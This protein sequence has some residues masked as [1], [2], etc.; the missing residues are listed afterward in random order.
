MALRKFIDVNT[1]SINSSKKDITSLFEKQLKIET[2][3]CNRIS[4][5]NETITQNQRS[6]YDITRS[7]D[8]NSS[9]RNIDVTNVVND[10]VIV[11]KP[12][13]EQGVPGQ[14]GEQG[15]PGPIGEQG[16]DGPVGEQGIHG[17][18]G[19]QGVPGPVG[20]QGVPGPIGE[21]GVP[22]PI[23]DQG[24]SGPIGEQGV[25]G[26]IGE[27]GVPGPIGEQLSVTNQ[28]SIKEVGPVGPEGVV[29]D[30]NISPVVC[31]CKC[32]CNS[33]KF[34]ESLRGEK[35]DHGEKG[36]RG[37]KG[38]KGNKGDNG[39]NG[40]VTKNTINS[41]DINYNV[42]GIRDAYKEINAEKATSKQV[43][44]NLNKIL[45]LLSY[46]KMVKLQ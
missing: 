4:E 40:V 42:S 26:P 12:V 16:I 8:E 17:P 6:I 27:Q 31:N 41:H 13:G 14:I 15:V 46:H 9:N 33:S 2:L 44:E 38:D 28:G 21:Q 19:E 30:T 3:L 10:T 20:E 45:R 43:A 23:G 24:A 11:E 1:R 22:G 5:M 7:T 37:E 29:V 35:G 18:V 36:D 34:V 39:D 32:L 25:P